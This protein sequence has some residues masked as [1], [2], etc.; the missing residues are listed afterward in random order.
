MSTIYN[1][2]FTQP[3]PDSEWKD[4]QWVEGWINH[5]RDMPFKERLH[6]AVFLARSSFG[7][8][9]LNRPLRARIQILLPIGIEIESRP[10]K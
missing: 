8:L 2:E 1:M 3:N 7:V 5:D 6:N 9:F 4:N 10:L